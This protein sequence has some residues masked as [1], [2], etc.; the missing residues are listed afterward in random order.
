MTFRIAASCVVVAAVGL[1]AAPA[2]TSA[3]GGASGGGRAISV[4]GGAS[5]GGFQARVTRP[6]APFVAPSVT[7]LAPA[8]R[9]ARGAPAHALSAA[10]F[11]HR[12]F[13][14]TGWPLSVWGDA[15]WYAGGYYDPSDTAAS[16]DQPDDRPG[17]SSPYSYPVYPSPDGTVVRERVIYVIPFRPGC[18]TQTYRVP[19]EG[20]GRRSINVVRC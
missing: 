6:A 9:A 10:Q 3:R 12:R 2:E 7:R 19:A 17:Y 8:G 20:G 4:L 15:P 5:H 11:R 1:I 18:G 14:A 13:F 16:G